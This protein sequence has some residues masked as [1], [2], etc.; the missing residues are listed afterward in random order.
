MP[1]HPELD[2][3]VQ[4]Q[5][6]VWATVLTELEAGEKRTHWMWCVFPQMKGLG[7]SPTAQQFAI[8]SLDES[9]S[10]LKH[11]VLGSRIRQVCEVILGLDGMSA[12]D[13]FGWPDELKL[14]SS[15]T[16]FAE[17]AEADSLF[18]AVLRKYFD[19]EKDIRTLELLEDA[20]N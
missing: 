1:S 17:V 2:R 15:M 16:L 6:T 7:K 12:N 20:S 8:R 3:F 10:Y 14:H 18:G 5:N 13:I 9:R 4:A 19:G 11:P